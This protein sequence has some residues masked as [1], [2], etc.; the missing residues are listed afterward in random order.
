MG[1]VGVRGYIGGYIRVMVGAKH[2]LGS[3]WGNIRVILGILEN[4]MET[5]MIGL[6][7]F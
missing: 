4:K 1:Y 5:I 2:V 7:R 6:L 3:H